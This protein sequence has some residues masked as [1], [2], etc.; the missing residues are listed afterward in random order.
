MLVCPDCAKEASVG[1]SCA[2]CGG[3]L[4]EQADAAQ[5][6]TSPREGLE[7]AEYEPL[8]ADVISCPNCHSMTVDRSVPPAEPEG[9][10][11]I[12]VVDPAGPSSARVSPDDPWR[13]SVR[14]SP[15]R[16]VGG[17]LQTS[18]LRA[19]LEVR[20]QRCEACRNPLS[21][22]ATTLD[23]ALRRTVGA[24]VMALI[25]QLEEPARTDLVEGS[26]LGLAPAPSD[27]DL[28]AVATEL[29]RPLALESALLGTVALDR[30]LNR[31]EGTHRLSRGQR[32]QVTFDRTDRGDAR[33][34][35]TAEEALSA[36][37]HRL[38]EFRS[39]VIEHLLPLYND[40]WRV[41][42]SRKATVTSFA[43]RLR[44]KS[45][46]VDPQTRDVE[47]AFD[48]GGMFTDHIILVAVPADGRPVLV[49]IAG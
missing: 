15:W 23:L 33:D 43:R 34:L 44:L 24:S 22:H 5:P 32:Y 21:T 41:R 6:L 26:V 13:T 27:P 47:L 29:Q 30:S 8:A 48:A 25:C 7:L 36:L 9:V 42:G 20:E 10:V 16:R 49:E 35:A 31:F 37:E 18:V 19:A 40:A 12:G 4:V 2:R 28:A 17:V 14:L 1:T 45:I 39:A 46:H 3:T 38:S 11:V